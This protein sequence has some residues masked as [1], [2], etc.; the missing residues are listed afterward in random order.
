MSVCVIALVAMAVVPQPQEIQM[1]EGV[2]EKDRAHILGG[3]GDNWSECT[4]NQYDLE[5]KMWPRGCALAE[6]FWSGNG[7][8]PFDDFLRRMKVHRTF[9]IQQGVNCAPLQ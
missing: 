6:V 7:K 3:Q 4:W 5:W 9:L 1:G 2:A 8:P